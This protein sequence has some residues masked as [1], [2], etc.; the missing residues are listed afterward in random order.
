MKALLQQETKAFFFFFLWWVKIW[1]S[2]CR[3]GLQNSLCVQEP[4]IT[5]ISY[6]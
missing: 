4:H 1:V 2:E 3:A 6:Q 5:P